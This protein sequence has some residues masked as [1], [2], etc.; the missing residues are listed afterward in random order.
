M[1]Q[2]KPVATTVA[3][4]VA[5]SALA[6]TAALAALPKFL[7]RAGETGTGKSGSLI[8]ETENR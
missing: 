8:F 2:L 7:P 1:K 5:L 3:A 4:A 6:S